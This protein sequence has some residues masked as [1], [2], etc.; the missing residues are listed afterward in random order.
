[1]ASTVS[2]ERVRLNNLYVKPR[3]KILGYYRLLPLAGR[4]AASVAHR[5]PPKLGHWT[6]RHSALVLSVCP[7]MVDTVAAIEDLASQRGCSYIK[8]HHIKQRPR[9]NPPCQ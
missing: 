8:G 6:A 2:V 9:Q 5:L 7:E 3:A 1:M 4:E